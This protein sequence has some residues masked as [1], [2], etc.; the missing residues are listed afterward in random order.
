[1]YATRRGEALAG[2]A[3][4]LLPAVAAG[5]VQ[6][7]ITSPPFA[8]TRQKSYG[9]PDEADYTDWFAPFAGEFRR[10]LAGDGSLVV[11]VG[12]AWR[13]GAPVRSL[14]Q[15]DLLASLVRD[16]GFFFAQDFYW[17]NPAALPA[18]AEWVTVRRVRAKQ[19]VSVIWWLSP[20]PNPKA[21]NRNVLKP[22]S[23]SQM[24]L[25]ASGVSEATRPSGHEIGAGFAED[26][27]GA[28]PPNLLAVSN[29]R[30]SD[31]YFDYCR[32]RGLPV[33]PARF[34]RE[35]PE[36]FIKMLTDPGDLVLD[37]FAGSNTTGAAAE[38][39]GRRWL[40]FESDADYLEGSMGRFGALARRTGAAPAADSG[41]P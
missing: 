31:P 22:Y 38:A 8:L 27:G 5:S 36:F 32:S 20:A 21:S 16:H 15:F 13:P 25:F 10:V 24:A 37:P 2:D 4:D 17:H 41:Q 14:Y 30:S 18:P 34:P 7:V 26:N 1:M 3:L 28:I 9:N 19:S 23:G 33:H 29:T 12:P 35:I 11:E 6:A 40:A 39:A